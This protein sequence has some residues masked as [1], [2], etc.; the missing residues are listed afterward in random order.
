MVP[1]TLLDY[2]SRGF[3]RDRTIYM[4]YMRLRN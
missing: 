1:E 4:P 3:D 2:L